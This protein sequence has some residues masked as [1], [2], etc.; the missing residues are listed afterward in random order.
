MKDTF[1]YLKE[2][3]RL[4]VSP[5][6]IMLYV[7]LIDL[8]KKSIENNLKDENGFFVIL[9]ITEIQNLLNCS[10]PTA[11]N[12]LRELEEKHYIIKNFDNGR[13]TK[14]YFVENEYL[15]AMT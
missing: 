13:P 3:L 4:K 8:Y 12:I 2:L 14:I 9:T 11:I 15:K 5:H 1:D 10:R 7:V 6:A